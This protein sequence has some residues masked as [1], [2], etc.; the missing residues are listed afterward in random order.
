MGPRGRGFGA[1]GAGNRRYHPRVGLSGGYGGPPPLS[2][3][4]LLRGRG[5]SIGPTLSPPPPALRPL[6][7]P[8]ATGGIFFPFAAP[9]GPIGADDAGGG[10]TADPTAGTPTGRPAA[11][12]A[13]FSARLAALSALRDGA[14]V[15]PAAASPSLPF[16]AHSRARG[17]GGSVGPS[18]DGAPR[19]RTFPRAC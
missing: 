9:P 5:W 10:A 14:L 13:R 6:T 11:P 12:A 16:L 8:G 2:L 4:Q 15:P 17:V 19:P 3:G 18:A 7:P 1:G